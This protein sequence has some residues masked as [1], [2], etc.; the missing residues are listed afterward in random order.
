MKVN[1]NDSDQI[2]LFVLDFLLHNTMKTSRVN[3][4]NT[5]KCY[6]VQ[7]YQSPLL[8]VFEVDKK[9]NS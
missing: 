1:C 5:K 7:P 2:G 9:V 8:H 6:S 3:A 4:H